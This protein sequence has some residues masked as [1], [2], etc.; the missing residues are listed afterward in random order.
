MDDLLGSA[1]A[2][3][4]RQHLLLVVDQDREVALEDIERIRVVPVKVRIRS[5]AGVREKRLGDAQLVEVRLDDDPSV[6]ERFAL[7]GSVHDSW[8][9]RRV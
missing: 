4:R 3:A 1:D 6:E 7:A 5:D 8:H 2:R 9:V